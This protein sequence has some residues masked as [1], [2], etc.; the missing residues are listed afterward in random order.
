MNWMEPTR[1]LIVDDNADAAD[2]LAAV[3]EMRG[4]D[5]H[6]AHHPMHALELAAELV[7]DIAF[8]DIGLPEIDGYELAARLR[9]LPGLSELRLI[10]LTGYGR[11]C[12]RARTRD[13]GFA[14]HLVKPVELRTIEATLNG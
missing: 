12:D 9:A 2:L 14:H 7:P 10:A 3:L 6:V 1:I 5:V 8:L 13:A 4:Y 11:D